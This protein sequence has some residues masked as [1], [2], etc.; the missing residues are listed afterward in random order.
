MLFS[1]SLAHLYSNRNF[2]RTRELTKEHSK[3][4]VYDSAILPHVLAAI[5]SFQSKLCTLITHGATG[6]TSS[7]ECPI[8]VL[9]HVFKSANLSQNNIDL[10][11]S[12]AC[13]VP[14]PNYDPTATK[15]QSHEYIHANEKVENDKV[16]YAMLPHWGEGVY[17]HSIA[18]L[19]HSRSLS[20]LKPRIGGPWFDLEKVSEWRD[21][22]AGIVLL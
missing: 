20:F 6:V 22:K 4:A 11:D 1:V 5:P 18:N 9:S 16:D 7:D 21:G 14:D 2:E 15:T 17:D 19:A 10:S 12:L 3:H 13:P 8:S